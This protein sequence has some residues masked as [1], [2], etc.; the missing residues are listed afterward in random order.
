MPPL[1]VV[2]ADDHQLFAETLGL[3]LDLQPTRC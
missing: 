3:T 1:R 2:I